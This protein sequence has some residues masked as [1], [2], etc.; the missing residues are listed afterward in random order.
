MP[1]QLGG[2]TAEVFKLLLGQVLDADQLVAGILGRIDQFVELEVD[3][4]RLAALDMPDEEEQQEA[5]D[6]GDDAE[7]RGPGL[8]EPAIGAD[9]HPGEDEHEREIEA[10]T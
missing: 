7:G 6:R 9:A 5:D 4:L 3:G 2:A 1:S 8:V 10:I